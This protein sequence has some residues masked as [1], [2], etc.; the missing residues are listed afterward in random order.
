MSSNITL[1]KIQASST[2]VR[3]QRRLNTGIVRY[4]Y[5]INTQSTVKHWKHDV[6]IREQVRSTSR[7]YKHCKKCVD[8]DCAT[9]SMIYLISDSIGPIAVDINGVVFDVMLVMNVIELTQIVSVSAVVLTSKK[10][11]TL[12]FLVDNRKLNVVTAR[13]SYS[14]PTINDWINFSK[15]AQVFSTLDANSSYWLTKVEESDKT[16]TA[17]SLQ[18]ELCQW[19]HCHLFWKQYWLRSSGTWTYCSSPSICRLHYFTSMM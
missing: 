10:D 19:P 12:C 18:H 2:E 9:V 7:T 14:P 15:N 16:N 6:T 4:L 17:L 8:L 13:R 11:G 1:V 3:Y 5:R